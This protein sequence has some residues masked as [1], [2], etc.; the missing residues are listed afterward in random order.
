MTATTNALN[1]AIA[2]AEKELGELPVFYAEQDVVCVPPS[3]LR[4]KNITAMTKAYRLGKIAALEEV[5]I[6]QWPTYEMIRAEID[7]LKAIE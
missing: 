6:D 4:D 5:I 3:L 2:E 7:A 1:D